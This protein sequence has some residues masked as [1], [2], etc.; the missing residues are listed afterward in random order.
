MARA[1]RVLA[2]CTM[3]LLCGGIH[4]VAAADFDRF[5]TAPSDLVK[6]TP[7]PDIIVELGGG[8]D[9][10]AA[11]QGASAQSF[12]FMPQFSLDSLNIPGL[13]DIDN[14]RIG[15]GSYGRGATIVAHVVGRPIILGIKRRNAHEKQRQHG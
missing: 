13:I 14:T 2:M 12:G 10:G 15:S 7:T 4:R 5:G 8:V 1:G 9:Y 3:V 6:P 11:Y